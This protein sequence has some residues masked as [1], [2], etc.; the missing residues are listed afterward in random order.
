MTSGSI[1]ARGSITT[2][3]LPQQEVG[4]WQVTEPREKNHIVNICPC[5]GLQLH[6]TSYLFIFE[7]G[8]VLVVTSLLM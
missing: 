4:D 2:L 7:L 5:I 8:I 1:V 3:G 6:N